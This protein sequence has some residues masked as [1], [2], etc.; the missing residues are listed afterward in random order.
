MTNEIVQR[1]YRSEI[2]ER[3]C[4]SDDARLQ[5][6]WNQRLSTVSSIFYRTKDPLSR[7]AASLVV[8]AA[9]A[10]DLGSIELLLQRL[11]GGA[12]SD[13]AVLESD[14]MPL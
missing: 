5:W 2:P 3:Y 4:T 12:V 14:S 13:Q 7:M 6:L 8:S 10:G 1:K 9:V 11:E